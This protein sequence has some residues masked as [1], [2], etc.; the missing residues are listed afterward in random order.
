MIFSLVSCN[1]GDNKTKESKETEETVDYVVTESDLKGSNKRFTVNFEEAIEGDFSK[2]IS[3]LEEGYYY[4]IMECAYEGGYDYC[5]AYAVGDDDNIIINSDDLSENSDNLNLNSDNLSLKSDNSSIDSDN[6]PDSITSIPVS[7]REKDVTVRGIEVGDSG[8]L[9]VGV[10]TSGDSSSSVTTKSFRLIKENNQEEKY[11]LLLGGALSRV[12]YVESTGAKFYDVNGEESDP[13]DVMQNNGINFCRLELYN[14]PG[15]GRGDGRYYCPEGFQNLDDIVDIAKRAK[16]HGMERQ[17]SFMLSDFWTYGIPDDFCK[18]LDVVV[19][20]YYKDTSNTNQTSIGDLTDA[21]KNYDGSIEELNEQIVDKLEEDTYDYIYNSLLRM[22]EE[23]VLPKYVSIGNEM[24]GGFYLP[25]GDSGKNMDNLARFINAGYKAVKDVSEDI[26]VVLHIGCNADDMKWEGSGTGK[27]FFDKCEET[28]VNYD[29][30][31][32][33]FYPF[34]AETLKVDD[35]TK[36]CNYMID[37]YDKDVLVMETGFN[38]REDTETGSRGQLYNMGAYEGIYDY[39]EEGQRDFMIELING[40]KSVKDGRCIGDLYWDP[41]MVAG[42]G[43]GWSIKEWDDKVDNN[44][45]SNTTWFDFDH[46]ALK[47]FDAYKYN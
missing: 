15:K 5:F 8:I 39:T 17:L 24:N 10:L 31:G 25:Y 30:I 29:V 14:N 3:G 45:I 1:N 7:K 38:Y 16:E 47:V 26:Q 34:W 12:N 33:S 19:Y 22:K 13:L 6:L 44:V 21:F 23:D 2:K 9:E 43:I 28:N 32:T 37:T 11:E 46:K 27:W 35:L 42:E 40:I 41:I 4:M 36:W 20:N 18:D